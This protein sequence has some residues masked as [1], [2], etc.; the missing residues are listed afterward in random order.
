MSSSKIYM[1]IQECDP[2]LVEEAGR[3]GVADLHESL[4]II[5]GRMALMQPRIKTLNRGQRISGQAVTVFLY[6]GDA[7]FLH[8]AVKMVQPGQILVIANGETSPSVM[9]AE[10]V[11]LAALKNGIAGVI[12]DGCIR[13]TE[14]LEEMRFPIWSAGF[15]CG[16]TEKRGPGAINLP[17]VCGGAIVEPGD[18]IVADGDGVISIPPDRLVDTLKNA[19]VRAER[20]KKIRDAI[21]AGEALFDIMNLDESM[22]GV[23]EYDRLWNT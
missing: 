16:H 13:D 12:A 7:L 4:G 8:R 11:A 23:E 1:R 2:A 10:L 5:P 20:E 15:Y 17:V 21:A 18:V 19:R 6:P 14:A 9:F 3:Y 22:K